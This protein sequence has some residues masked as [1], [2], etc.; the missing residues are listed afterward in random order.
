MNF[1]PLN[2]KQFRKQIQASLTE[3]MNR[4]PFLIPEPTEQPIDL[5][6]EEKTTHATVPVQLEKDQTDAQQVIEIAK[7]TNDLAKIE[8]DE[9]ARIK[10]IIESKYRAE[11]AAQQKANESKRILELKQ[12]I[13]AENLLKAQLQAESERK[14]MLEALKMKVQ[15][16]DIE[17][18]HLKTLYEMEHYL[19]FAIFNM[20]GDV[21]IEQHFGDHNIENIGINAAVIMSSALE[22]FDNVGLGVVGFIQLNSDCGTFSAAWVLENQLFAAIL[23]APEARNLALAKL[24]LNKICESIREQLC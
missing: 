9:Q 8:A 14:S 20:L 17:T 18:I 15:A 24:K 16:L 4:N 6:I 22:A 11:Q 2:N 3:L 12:K 10:V 23:F 1:R 13:D 19:A 7:K 5:L 21:F